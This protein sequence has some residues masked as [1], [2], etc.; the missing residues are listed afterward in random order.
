[1][2]P[3]TRRVSQQRRASAATPKHPRSTVA[4][5]QQHVQHTKDIREQETDTDAARTDEIE[6]PSSSD[7]SRS[8]MDLLKI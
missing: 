5:R 7:A 6:T 3:R 1:V 8:F 2:I 4:T